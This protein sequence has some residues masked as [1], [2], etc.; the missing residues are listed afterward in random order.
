MVQNYYYLPDINECS[1]G[2]D[3][4]DHN[5]HNSVGSY[6]CSC[7]AGYRLHHDDTTCNSK[8][9]AKLIDV[10]DYFLYTTLIQILMNVLKAQM[11]VFILVQTPRVA[12]NALVTLAIG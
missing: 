9:E 5:C 3:V 11:V 2:T 1:E 8:L 4:C 7:S 6:Y 12:M 10:D